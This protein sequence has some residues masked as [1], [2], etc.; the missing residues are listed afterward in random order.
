MMVYFT[1]VGSGP[2]DG[3]NLPKWLLLLIWVVIV[4]GFTAF[5]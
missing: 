5:L 2:G 4:I 1:P 3:P